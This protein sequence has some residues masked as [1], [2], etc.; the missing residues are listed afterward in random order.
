M[1]IKRL[2]T[3]SINK[4]RLAEL[5]NSGVMSEVLLARLDFIEYE[6]M[7]KDLVKLSKTDRVFTEIL[8]TQ[9]SG[10]WSTK[11]PNLGGF[12]REFWKQHRG[13]IHP[14]PGEWW[15]DFDWSG[16]EARMFISYSGDE[17]DV[18]L[19]QSKHCKRCSHVHIPRTFLARGPIRG[20][21]LFHAEE[22]QEGDNSANDLLLV[23]RSGCGRASRE[24]V[25][26]S[27]VPK[28][29][30]ITERQRGMGSRSDQQSSRRVDDV[31]MASSGRSTEIQNSTNSE[32]M[33]AP[34]RIGS[35]SS[36]LG[37]TACEC[38]ETTDLTPLDLHT[39]TCTKYLM[40]WAPDLSVDSPLSGYNLPT[41]W[42]GGKDERRTRAKNFRYGV[43]Q[44]G[45]SAKAVL[46][47][48]GIESLGLDRQMLLQRAQRFLDARPKAQAWK[49]MIW[50]RCRTDK[51]ARTFMGRRRK[52]FGPDEDRA[53]D[54]LN[55]MIQG[56]V[57]D[58]MDWVLIEVERAWPQG[59]LILNK[60]DGAILAFPD[61]CPVEPTWAAVRL[62]VEREWEI[63]Q[64]T[65]AMRFPAEWEVIHA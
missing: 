1:P 29:Q 19:L 38:S 10:R 32:P 8:P 53:K 49:E 21:G 3:R 2:G 18:L 4:D 30:T 65:P 24:D 46:G 12:K 9:A 43:G 64:G 34:A 25:G 61:S 56:S 23:N 58:L 52:L 42:Q 54:G 40:A 13:I 45:T 57:A 28:N 51:E 50:E 60:H 15:L 5:R 27:R 48:P 44:Y 39:F 41:D 17:E 20:R 63:G 31:T 14:D 36:S 55:H 33:E 11:N 35:P 26:S 22:S 37:C 47:M 16:I 59:H 7:R 6:G 62:I